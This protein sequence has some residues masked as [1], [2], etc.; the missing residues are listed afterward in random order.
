MAFK[1]A[2][3]PNKITVI[4]APTSAGAR[5]TGQEQAPAALRA[6]GLL[7][8]LRNA[9]F[10]VTD[11]GDVPVQVFEPDAEHPRAQNAARAV[12]VLE[13]LRPL[14]E[15]AVRAGTLPILLG[16]DCTISMAAVAGV[17]RYYHDISMIYFDRDADLNTPQTTPSGVLD[18]MV[19][20]HLTGR[21][22]PE[23]VRFAAEP[24]L[25][26]EPDLAIFGLVRLDP[27]EKQWLERSALRTYT[28]EEIRRK[29]VGACAEEALKRIHANKHQICLHFDVD[30]ISSEEFSGADVPDTG[31]LGLAEV[32]EALETF[33]R[34]PN[35]AAVAITEYNPAHDPEGKGAGMIA[36]MLVAAL[37]PRLVKKEA[38]EV[39]EVV[40]QKEAEPVVAVTTETA[41]EVTGEPT[42]PPSELAPA[43]MESGPAQ[44]EIASA[45]TTPP[46][47][48]P[49]ETETV[50]ATPVEQAEAVGSEPAVPAEP[51][52]P[53]IPKP[54]DSGQAFAQDKPS[55]PTEQAEEPTPKPR[56]ESPSETP[57]TP[58]PPS[59]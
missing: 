43:P 46:E 42:P 24:P 53:S 14:V 36:D 25:V 59:E 38:E 51:F 50:E 2:R 37:A 57:E 39:K 49:P 52:D 31:G 27:P 17:R 13:G 48:T 3:Y 28:A 11:A 19:V 5:Q 55:E 7:D 1:I 20:A 8:K 15:Q 54:R 16:G 9:G 4:G 12:K 26:R 41:T 10:E 30:V 47:E 18:G 58:K 34:T 29:G 44:L 21:G 56:E 33:A 40:E 32:R 6:A 23:L 45:A 35:L 22:A